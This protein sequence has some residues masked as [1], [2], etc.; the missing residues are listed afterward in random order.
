MRLSN[1]SNE[2]ILRDIKEALKDPKWKEAINEKINALEEQHLESGKLT[3]MEEYHGVQE[4]LAPVTKIDSIQ[5][6]LSLATNNDWSLQQLDIK[7]V[8]LHGNLE[9]VFM[10]APPSFKKYF[11][12][13]NDLEEMKMVKLK[14]AKE[15]EIKD[16]Y[17]LRY[18]LSIEVARSKKGKGWYQRLVG[19]LIYL[20]HTRHDITYIVGLVSQFMHTPMNCHIEAM[21]HIF[22]YLKHTRGKGLLFEKQDQCDWGGSFT[23]KRSTL[24]YCTFVARNLDVEE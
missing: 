11:G 6:L 8:I 9:K 16:L 12:T 17:S 23:H 22:R 2:T 14:L 15:F 3:Q 5:V 4:T 21:T 7:N 20:S 18:F 19:K 13:G 24:G 10:N 1:L